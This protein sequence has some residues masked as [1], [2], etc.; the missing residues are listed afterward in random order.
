MR[1]AHRASLLLLALSGASA[2]FRSYWNV[3]LEACTRS[4]V[5]F[6]LDQFRIIHNANNTF[7]GDKVN[8]YYSPGLFP[9]YSDEGNVVNGGIP[10]QGNL[11]AHLSRFAEQLGATATPGY[12]GV[13]VI[14]FERYLPGNN[15]FLPRVYRDA[16][17]QWVEERHPTWSPQRLNQASVFAFNASAKPFFRGVLEEATGQ[18]PS[19]L[20]GHYHYPYCKNYNAP[21]TQCKPEMVSFN[22]ALQEV[23]FEA[24]SALFPSAYLYQAHGEAYL[25]YLNTGLAETRRVNLRGVPELPYFWYRYHENEAPAYLP[26]SVALQ[27]L[28]AIRSASMTG[29]V[30]WGSSADLHDAASCTELKEYL[31]SF[32]GPL[33]RCLDDLPEVIVRALATAYP[34]AAT[35]PGGRGDA[36]ADFQQNRRVVEAL[37]E[38]FCA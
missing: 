8:I 23:V 16:S 12:D 22:D 19:A 6:D 28:W 13:T 15:G 32:L 27:A 5:L 2:S 36:S 29:V 20:A 35:A 1:G 30:L 38:A 24:S 10:Q 26:R 11:S 18:Q 33:L 34:T 3:P 14:D 31:Y 9:Y 4:G 17:L 25:D 21:Y 37:L 7:T